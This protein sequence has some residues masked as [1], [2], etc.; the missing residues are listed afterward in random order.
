[1][2]TPT[3]ETLEALDSILA[4]HGELNEETAPAILVQLC[5]KLERERDEARNQLHRICKDG[6]DMQDTISLEPA[7]DY[8]LRQVAAMRDAIKEAQSAVSA[9]LGF[10]SDHLSNAQVASLSETL[11]KLQP[12]IKP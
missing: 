10:H 11:S 7:D 6:F 9:F 4:E 3:P 2:S 1:M 8:V 12:F 5:K